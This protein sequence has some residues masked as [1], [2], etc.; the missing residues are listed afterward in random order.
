MK[1]YILIGIVLLVAGIV[2]G[3]NVLDNKNDIPLNPDAKI[4]TGSAVK[5]IPE[6]MDLNYENLASFL[7]KTSMIKDM[8]VSVVNLRLNFL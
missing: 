7:S 4:P 3:S 1:K 8:P 5:N 2:V 6:P